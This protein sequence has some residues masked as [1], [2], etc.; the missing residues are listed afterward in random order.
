M[1]KDDTTK[2]KGRDN[3]LSDTSSCY[4]LTYNIFSGLEKK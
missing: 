4:T 1:Y 2:D 3:S